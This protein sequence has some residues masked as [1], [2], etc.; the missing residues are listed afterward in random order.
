LRRFAPLR[1][2][3][4]I[5]TLEGARLQWDSRHH[6]KNH[7]YEDYYDYSIPKPR[8]PHSQ[9][10]YIASHSTLLRPPRHKR[11]EDNTPHI[12]L[13]PIHPC[14]VCRR[15][16][17]QSAGTVERGT[18]QTTIDALVGSSLLIFSML[19]II[20]NNTKIAVRV[21]LPTTVRHL[22]TPPTIRTCVSDSPK[23]MS[24]GLPP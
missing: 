3:R 14:Q 18:K 4:A 24:F 10:C 19:I 7:S 1:A 20:H 6:S 23:P 22:E 17:G 5:A 8:G 2:A 13:G 15:R 21:G 9:P 12:R 16:C 11:P